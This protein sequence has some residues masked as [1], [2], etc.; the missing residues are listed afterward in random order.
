M[1]AA[2]SKF[3]TFASKYGRDPE[4]DTRKELAAKGRTLKEK[5]ANEAST[6]DVGASL[7]EPEEQYRY[8][9]EVS[10]L[11]NEHL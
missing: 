2:L 7:R 5:L 8:P 9:V 3:S 10:L 4:S 11:D 1:T 6:S